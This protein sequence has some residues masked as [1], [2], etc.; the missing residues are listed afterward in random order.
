MPSDPP[1]ATKLGKVVRD[2]ALACFRAN[3]G[4]A[5]KPIGELPVVA[6]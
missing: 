3:K 1:A 4:W 5:D 6:S 2:A